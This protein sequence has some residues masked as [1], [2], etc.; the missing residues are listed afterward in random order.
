LLGADAIYRAPMD[1]LLVFM[2]LSNFNI[3]HPS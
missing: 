1:H 3:I 2:L